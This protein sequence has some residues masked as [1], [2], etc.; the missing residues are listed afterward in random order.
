MTTVYRVYDDR[1]DE[2]LFQGVTNI[3]CHK[4]ISLHFL[5]DDVDYEHIWIEPVLKREESK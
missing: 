3:E 4:W 5:G 2:T 1:T